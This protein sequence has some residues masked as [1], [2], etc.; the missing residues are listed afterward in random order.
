[1]PLAGEG[2]R[3]MGTETVARINLTAGPVA[4]QALFDTIAYHDNLFFAALFNTGDLD[5]IGASITEDFEFYH[6]KWGLL[7][8]SRAQFVELMRAS[9][10]R[11]KRG[12]DFRARRELDP[13]SMV[14]YPL[15]QYGAIQVGVHGFMR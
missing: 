4:S 6:D 8:T 12:V 10:E 11:Q 7:A 5:Q 14:V 1:M 9:H 15:N 2:E 3:E 13:S